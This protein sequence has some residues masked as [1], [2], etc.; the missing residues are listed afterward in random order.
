MV[1]SPTRWLSFQDPSPVGWNPAS[2]FLLASFFPY[3]PPPMLSNAGLL[4]S[5]AALGIRNFS[6]LWTSYSS[7]LT[8]PLTSLPD[9]LP[10]TCASSRLT[11][12]PSFSCTPLISCKVLVL[13]VPCSWN[14]LSP[15]RC[16]VHW[17]PSFRPPLLCHCLIAT[18]P[19]NSF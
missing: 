9:I 11:P 17:H 6:V 1:R 15:H 8:V 12:F 4:Q 2:V 13:T 14:T 18:I 3:T 10:C 16:R 7:G 5:S 19:D